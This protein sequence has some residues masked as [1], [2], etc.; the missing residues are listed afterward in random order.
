MATMGFEPYLR[1]E[2]RGYIITTYRY[3][4][5]PAFRFEEFYTRLSEL[6]FII[7]PGKLSQEPCFR[8]GTIGRLNAGDIERLL[9][10]IRIVMQDM[11]KEAWWHYIQPSR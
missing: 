4:K 11:V 7:Y 8:V 1:A 2:D 9:E 10:A 3:P 5:D 6:G